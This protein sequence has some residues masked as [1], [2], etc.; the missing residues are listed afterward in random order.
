M[1][2]YWEGAAFGVSDACGRH[3]DAPFTS[4]RII[5]QLLSDIGR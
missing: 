2:Q 5:L 3:K 4:I 1:I